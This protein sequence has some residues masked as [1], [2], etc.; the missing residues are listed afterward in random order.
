[1]PEHHDTTAQRLDRIEAKLDGAIASMN[2]SLTAQQTALSEH[3]R[4]A[5]TSGMRAE[6]DDMQR[7][8]RGVEDFALEARVTTRT[9]MRIVQLTFGASLI[10]AVASIL[11]IAD[12]ISRGH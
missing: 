3:I 6:A 4:A 12:L 2:T 8:I 7:R 9:L 5:D 11:A 1:M 10:G